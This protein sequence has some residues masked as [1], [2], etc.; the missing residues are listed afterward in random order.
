MKSLLASCLVLTL[1][2][3]S[4][5]MACGTF[6]E[7]KQQRLDQANLVRERELAH[8]MARNSEL[9]LVGTVRALRRPSLESPTSGQVTLEVVEVLK[10]L[11]LKELSLPW[12]EHFVL[13]A[14]DMSAMF[15]N[16]GFREDVSY[17]VYVE[18]GQIVRTNSV[19]RSPGR[20]S[21]SFTEERA[22]VVSAGGT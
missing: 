22:I 8:Q 17:I 9:V 11:P 18:N 4:H 1:A 13:S 20:A 16:V 15:R 14:C 3:P 19:E 5:A 2:L 7:P 10:G 12:Q 6:A 21:L